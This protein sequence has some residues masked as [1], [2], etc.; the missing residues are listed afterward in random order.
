MRAAAPL[1]VAGLWLAGA[2]ARGQTP[3][4]STRVAQDSALRVFLDCPDAFCD[5]DYYRTEITFVNW[6]RDRQFAQV[7]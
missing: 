4:D 2:A 1:L 3:Q 7:H 5:F 6:V